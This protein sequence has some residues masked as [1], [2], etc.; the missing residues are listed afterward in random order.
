[1]RCA[2]I[3]QIGRLPFRVPMRGILFW[4]SFFLERDKTSASIGVELLQLRP[5]VLEYAGTEKEEGIF[6][7]FDD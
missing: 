2:R 5:G 4:Q 7:V 3:R 1:M 6:Y